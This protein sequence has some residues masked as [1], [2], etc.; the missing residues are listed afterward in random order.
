MKS[1]ESEM[2]QNRRFSKLSEQFA[3]SSEQSEMFQSLKTLLNIAEYS[4]NGL[5]FP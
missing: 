3:F 1:E 2:S 4:K 5:K